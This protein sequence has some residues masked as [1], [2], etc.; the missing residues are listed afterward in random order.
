MAADLGKGMP[1]YTGAGPER[2]AL[3]AYLQELGKQVKP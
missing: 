3:V 1:A 2:A